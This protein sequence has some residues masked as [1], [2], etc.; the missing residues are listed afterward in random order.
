[1]IRSSTH[2][3][4]MRRFAAELRPISVQRPGKAPGANV[5]DSGFSGPGRAFTTAPAFEPFNAECYRVKREDDNQN[6]IG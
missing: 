3:W 6:Q 4:G 5:N 2:A 1:M